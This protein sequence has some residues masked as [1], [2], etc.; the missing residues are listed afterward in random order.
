MR[1]QHLTWV[2]GGLT[3][4]SLRAGD[5]AVYPTHSPELAPRDEAWFLLNNIGAEIEHSL[6]VQYLYAA[7]SFGPDRRPAHREEVL[8]WKMSILEIAREEM[9]H[10]AAVQNLLRLITALAGKGIATG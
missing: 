1:L 5:Q 3:R 6:M 2:N 10:L 9:G 8:K 4:A 7:Y